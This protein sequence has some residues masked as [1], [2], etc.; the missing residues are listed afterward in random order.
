MSSP[1]E[2]AGHGAHHGALCRVHGKCSSKPSLS[3]CG[4]QCPV[5]PLVLLVQCLWLTHPPSQ[6]SSAR[7]P[8]PACWLGGTSSLRQVPSPA[9]GY[10]PGFRASGT[11]PASASFWWERLLVLPSWRMGQPGW[12]SGPWGATCLKERGIP[13]PPRP[14]GGTH[15]RGPPL[16]LGSTPGP[17]QAPMCTCKESVSPR[18]GH[19][20]PPPSL[21]PPPIRGWREGEGE[22]ANLQCPVPSPAD[23]HC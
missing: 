18:W 21:D 7:I 17:P 16:S 19:R 10:T 2:Q 8:E 22:A 4:G 23:V 15:R 14:R 12:G 9:S 13:G 11:G 6:V 5:V 3:S 1:L 20:N